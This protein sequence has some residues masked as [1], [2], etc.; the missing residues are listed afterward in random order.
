MENPQVTIKSSDMDP[1][2]QQ[3]AVDCAVFAVGRFSLEKDIAASIKRDFDR[4]YGPS[5]SCFVGNGFGSYFTHA[6]GHFMHL[7]V[8]PLGIVLFYQK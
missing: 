8:G 1:W 7:C 3:D 5:W 6:T 4:E 2:M